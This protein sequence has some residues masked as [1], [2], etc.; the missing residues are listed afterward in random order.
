VDCEQ[1][2]DRH[3]VLVLV[4]FIERSPKTKPKKENNTVLKLILD[5]NFTHSQACNFSEKL[6]ITPVHGR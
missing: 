6:K 1:Q 5:I 2:Y 4:A 3:S